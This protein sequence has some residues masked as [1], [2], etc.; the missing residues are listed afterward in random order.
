MCIRDRAYNQEVIG[1]CGVLPRSVWYK[2]HLKVPTAKRG[3]IKLEPIGFEFN[4]KIL[5]FLFLTL[6]AIQ[7]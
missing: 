6:T 1:L 5:I 4:E 7:L 2:K 3:K